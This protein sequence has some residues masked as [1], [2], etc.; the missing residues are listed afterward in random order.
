MAFNF[1]SPQPQ[2]SLPSKTPQLGKTWIPQQTQSGSPAWK[3][4]A[5]GEVRYQEEMPGTR[6][7]SPPEPAQAERKPEQGGT[8]PTAP[9]SEPATGRGKEP[10]SSNP[11]TQ[12]SRFAGK[13]PN[14]LKE[15]AQMYEDNIRTRLQSNQAVPDSW[16]SGID[17]V[18]TLLA[19][20]NPATEIQ[21]DESIYGHPLNPLNSPGHENIIPIK[22]NAKTDLDWRLNTVAKE[23]DKLQTAIGKA[24]YAARAAKT[25]AAR[26]KA[27]QELSSSNIR[28]ARDRL[29]DLRQTRQYL[30]ELQEK[31]QKLPKP[32][33]EAIPGGK[34]AGQD[35]RPKE[36]AATKP[37]APSLESWKVSY[38]EFL[39][40]HN[41]QDSRYSRETW[42]NNVKKAASR[43]LDV[44]DENLRA[45]G[46][47]PSTKDKTKAVESR[48]SLEKKLKAMGV[49][50]RPEYT[51]DQLQRQLNARQD[52]ARNSF[53]R[54]IETIQPPSEQYRNAPAN[55]KQNGWEIVK[56]GGQY[57]L[58][59]PVTKHK[60]SSHAVLYDAQRTAATL[61]P[62]D[63]VFNQLQPERHSLK[64]LH[65][66]AKN[67][68]VN[69]Y[70][71]VE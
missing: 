14:E 45:I 16:K 55:K 48:Q 65:D 7:E 41:A 56:V 39:K 32:P 19:G 17:E 36:E 29:N 24:E 22:I 53:Q 70:A 4:T 33:Q 63:P 64:H 5:T 62:D 3:N 11:E 28:E 54:R 12:E 59:H 20:G 21:T 34:A 42:E 67:L 15:I 51:D 49:P 37:K 18:R 27:Q 61:S 60:V 50:F 66:F 13:S 30:G 71:E 8:G 52:S 46:I 31:Q 57:T 9:E 43:G 6:A 68:Y 2:V 44:P 10:T 40:H 35:E 26:K 23:I 1:D 25:P 38:P 69:Y 58:R 47:D